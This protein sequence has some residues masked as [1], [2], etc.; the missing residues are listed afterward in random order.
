M[1]LFSSVLVC[2]GLMCERLL[3]LRERLVRLVRVVVAHAQ[4][5]ARV[6]VLRIEF[7]RLLVP[8][9]RVVPALG[10]EVRI[11]ELNSRRPRSSGRS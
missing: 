1:P 5:G 8:L 4:V 11:A 10:I 6:R 2:F 7:E 9:D 3:E